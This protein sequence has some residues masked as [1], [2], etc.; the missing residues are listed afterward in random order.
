MSYSV[1]QP[2]IV[3]PF[4][5]LGDDDDTY[6]LLGSQSELDIACHAALQELI[7]GGAVPSLVGLLTTMVKWNQQW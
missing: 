6:Q 5:Q 1:L 2:P 7:K 4:Q 3:W